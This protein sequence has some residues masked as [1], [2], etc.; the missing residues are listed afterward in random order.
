LF[1]TICDYVALML[2]DAEIVQFFALGLGASA[3]FSL[4]G[5]AYELAVRALR[6][7]VGE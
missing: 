6:V 5:F 3:L 4:T 1:L 2:T 7:T